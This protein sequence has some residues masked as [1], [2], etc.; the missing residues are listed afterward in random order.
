MASALEGGRF[1]TEYLDYAALTAQCQ[2]WARDFPELVKLESIGQSGQGRELWLLTLGP[3]PDRVRPGV[4]VDG[5]IHASELCGTNAAL[6]IAEDVLR[7]HLEPS[8]PLH[9][10]PGHLRDV[11]RDVL[12]YVLP[13]MS[14]D[15][16]EAVLKSGRW[17]RSV[18]RDPQPEP[19]QPRWIAGDVDGDGLAL[20]M[21]KL[22]ASG[23]YVAAPGEPSLLIPRRLEDEGP[24]Y[25]LYPEG[26]VESFDGRRIPD[27]HFLSD[28]SPDLNRNFPWTWM[29]EPHQEG[30]GAFPGSEPESRAV[31]EHAARLPNLFAWLAF[32]TFGGVFIRPLGAGPDTKME[33]GDLALFSEIGEASTAATGY[34]MVSGF[35]EFT[36]QA[37][38]PLHGDAS[39]FAYHAR[40]CIAYVC[41]LWDLFHRIGMQRPKRFCDH[42]THLT[43]DDF[44]RLARWDREHNQSRI[45]RPWKAFEHPQLGPVEIG[46][47]DPRVGIWNPPPEEIAGICAA[48]ARAFLRVAAMAPR[49]VLE[50]QS[51]ALGNGVSRVSVSVENLG[52]LPTHVLDS[53][54]ALP[55]NEPPWIEIH[56]EDGIELIGESRLRVGHLTGWGRGGFGAGSA[57]VPRSRG[58]SQV[59]HG[60][61]L[62]RGHGTATV[63]VRSPRLGRI[64]RK[65]AIPER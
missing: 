31:V 59:W 32:H 17:V 58:N 15:G 65:V 60:A 22:D 50:A 51:E 16:A 8:A 54:Q 39:D 14:P 11:L 47:F 57:I 1:R 27:P 55:H 20:L 48:Q 41:E 12:F 36:Y 34:P 24:Y 43:R 61:F 42:Y 5:N 28:N 26:H 13:R 30:G 52:Y 9:E 44:M 3:E 56:G 46:G 33:A 53:T 19:L 45:Y 63:L 4:W 21:R 2:A 38:K 18:P 62:V 6:G 23:E 25:K 10:L 7:L 29:P 35:E 37:D 40:G 49:L 64:A